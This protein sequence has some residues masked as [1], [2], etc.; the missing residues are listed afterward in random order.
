MSE[1]RE[2][3]NWDKA[4]Q[5][6]RDIQEEILH[7]R[8]LELFED[9]ERLLPPGKLPE[10]LEQ[11]MPV[12]PWDPDEGKVRKRLAGVEK[13]AKEKKPKKQRGHEIPENGHIGFKSVSELLKECGKMPAST[14]AP[15]AK[16]KGKSRSKPTVTA[17]RIRAKDENGNEI[18]DPW[19]VDAGESIEPVVPAE[20]SVSKGKSA[21]KGKG[22][23]ASA[24]K[25]RIKEVEPVQSESE[26]S[27]S[28]DDLDDLFANIDKRQAEPHGLHRNKQ[29]TSAAPSSA[30]HS[31]TLVDLSVQRK[32][33]SGQNMGNIIEDSD[34]DTREETLVEEDAPKA[35]RRAKV[36]RA[37]SITRRKSKKDVEREAA[38]E[39]ARHEAEVAAQEK[40]AQQARDQAALDFFSTAGLPRRKGITPHLAT[41]PSSPPAPRPETD[42]PMSPMSQP[43][44]P[45]PFGRDNKD[46]EEDHYRA[47]GGARL[48][49][50]VAAMAGFSQIAPIDLEWEDDLTSSPPPLPPQKSTPI[51]GRPNSAPVVPLSPSMPSSGQPSGVR[52][53][54]MGISRPKASPNPLRA[55]ASSL[56]MPPPPVPLHKS[57]PATTSP[58]TSMRP[59]PLVPSSPAAVT[60]TPP[61]RGTRRVLGQRNNLEELVRQRRRR[62][63]GNVVDRGGRKRRKMSD[64][65]G[66]YVCKIITTDS[67]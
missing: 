15:V 9:V 59:Q 43:R 44:S 54:I 45:L 66:R 42:H 36:S 27:V 13:E 4:Q 60:P 55:S 35:S 8:N 18:L 65:V 23:A 64:D 28:D 30:G 46:K 34:E 48:S 12:D 11:E 14:K 39:A 32:A 5:T 17:T 37:K 53:R 38:E 6:H 49:P 24:V 62:N 2:D 51:S 63:E 10:C 29:D 20:I 22:K 21:V 47:M 7:S 1:G 61:R 33:S 40:T 41:P 52:R 16:A 19:E 57:S 58:A 25:K 3:A 31:E 67:D 50:S 56:A 26:K